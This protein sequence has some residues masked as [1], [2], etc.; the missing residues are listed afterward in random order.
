[1]RIEGMGISWPSVDTQ[2]KKTN[3]LGKDDFLK[4]L[5]TQL[6]HQ[7]PLRPMEDKEFIAQLAQFSTL[8]QIQNLSRDFTSMKALGLVGRMIYAEK[9]IENTSQ[10]IPILGRVESTALS[11][12][13]VYI[14]VGEHDLLLEDIIAVFS[15]DKALE[16][17]EGLQGEKNNEK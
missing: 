15:D 16:I 3:Q 5:I 2:N 7:D 12:G 4:I 14:R 1:M 11:G 9:R 13:K 17:E 6:Q 10:I 8:E